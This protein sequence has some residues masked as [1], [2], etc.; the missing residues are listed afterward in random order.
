MGKIFFLIIVYFFVCISNNVLVSA[1]NNMTQNLTE[2]NSSTS[3]TLKKITITVFPDTQDFIKNVN[4]NKTI[5]YAN[6]IS[7]VVLHVGDLSVEGKP[8]DW[9]RINQSF[10]KLNVPFIVSAGNHDLYG[11][12]ETRTNVRYRQYLGHEKYSNSSW[13]HG[14][15]EFNGYAIFNMSNYSFGVVFI[16][17]DINTTELH[18]LRNITLEKNIS[19]ILLTHYYFDLYGK[20]RDLFGEYIYENLVNNS[21]IIIVNAGHQHG[22]TD[23]VYK[24]VLESMTAHNNHAN[25]PYYSET[26]VLIRTY[27]IYPDLNKIHIKSFIPLSN[28]T[29]LEFDYNLTNKTISYSVYNPNERSPDEYQEPPGGGSSTSS[30]TGGGTIITSINSTNNQTADLIE[31]QNTVINEINSSEKSLL[32]NEKS[33]T[34]A[35]IGTENSFKNTKI[36]V[37]FIFIII[38][39][40]FCLL[41]RRD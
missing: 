19:F 40:L 2:N 41:K 23:R 18:F 13:Y 21:N 11:T 14:F 36:V 16:D 8:S 37:S 22:N 25:V 30:S 10:S 5:E 35:V 12:N 4:L 26:E 1:E 27:E 20:E 3:E 15:S 31:T 39:L 7:D 9:D 28:Y 24:G 33:I 17:Q 32:T 38:G 29:L 6:N 34:G